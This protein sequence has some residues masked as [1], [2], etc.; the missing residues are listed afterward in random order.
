[1]AKPTGSQKSRRAAFL[2]MSDFTQCPPRSTKCITTSC[3]SQMGLLEAQPFLQIFSHGGHEEGSLVITK[4]EKERKRKKGEVYSNPPNLKDKL[5]SGLGWV[6]FH[7]RPRSVGLSKF[8][9][10]ILM[11][12]KW[13]FGFALVCVSSFSLQRCPFCPLCQALKI[14]QHSFQALRSLS[15]VLSFIFSSFFSIT[16]AWRFLLFFFLSLFSCCC[17]CRQLSRRL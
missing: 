16:F 13:C 15:L 8:I 17:I 1:M 14:P 12:E 9:L 10:Q 3:T 7:S 6:Q 4:E 11:P 2:E 5:A